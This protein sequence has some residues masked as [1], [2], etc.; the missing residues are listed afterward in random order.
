MDKKKS[1]IRA[2]AVLVVALAAGH[3]VQ[4]MNADSGAAAPA[5]P[6]AVEQVSAGPAA[7]GS[8]IPA[9]A[10]LTAPAASELAVTS[11]SEPAMQPEEMPILAALPELPGAPTIEATPPVPIMDAGPVAET[12]DPAP[13]MPAPELADL[14]D[15]QPSSDPQPAASPVLADSDCSLDMALSAGPQAMISVAISAPCRGGQ[16]V[17]LRHGGLAVAE[18]L[19][20]EGTLSLD[21]PALSDRGEVSVLFA[22]AEVLRDNVTVPDAAAVHR[23]AVQ[24]MADDSFQLHAFENGAD[25]GEPGNVS[26]EAPVSPDGGFMVALGNP[27]LDLPMMAQVYTWPADTSV[28]AEVVIEAAVTEM[29]CGRELLGETVEARGGAV[30][31]TDLTLAMPDCDAVGDIL[32][33]KN[34]GQDVTLAAAN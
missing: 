16:R 10:A 13:A 3:L 8:G 27:T 7:S 1:A 34:P 22:D 21:F 20:A 17:V 2:G 30:Q 5:A 4:T 31:V 19:T 12:P 9:A 33:L 24:W 28:S 26:A 11:P 32:V 15:P 6:K 23:F 29:T 18:E 14:A 25:Y